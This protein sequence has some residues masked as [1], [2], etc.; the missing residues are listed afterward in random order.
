MNDQFNI[1]SSLQ[2]LYEIK[3]LGSFHIAAIINRDSD[4]ISSF[5]KTHPSYLLLQFVAVSIKTCGLCFTNLLF[6]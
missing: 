4:G 6:L 1:S 5:D 3:S 2:Q